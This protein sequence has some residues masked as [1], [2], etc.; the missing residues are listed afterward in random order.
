MTVRLISLDYQ[1]PKC[2]TT[3]DQFPVVIGSGPEAGIC[4]E[5]PT[6]ALCHCR[7]E[8]SDGRLY[9]RDLGTVHGTFING[10]RIIEEVLMPG[11]EVAIGL[12]SFYVQDLQTLEESLELDEQESHETVAV[13]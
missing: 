1:V 10:V 3:L 9:V 4:L 2:D 7:I 8:Q 5:E 13:V 12:I 11:D 6:V